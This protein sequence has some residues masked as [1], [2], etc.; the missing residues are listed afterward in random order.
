MFNFFKILLIL[1][2]ESKKKRYFS[3]P[4]L[5]KRVPRV[6]LIIGVLYTVIQ[7]VGF[8]CLFETKNESSSTAK[9]VD[10]P[11]ATDVVAEKVGKI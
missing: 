5:L 7:L 8:L 1:N 6:F 10:E 11:K 2:V 4:S 3:Q 9:E